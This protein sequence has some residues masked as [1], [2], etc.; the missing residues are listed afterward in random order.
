MNLLHRMLRPCPLRLCGIVVVLYVNNSLLN[1][2]VVTQNDP[3]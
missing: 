3:K 1:L 2:F